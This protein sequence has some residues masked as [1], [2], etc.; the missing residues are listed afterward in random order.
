MLKKGY[1]LVE[2]LAVISTVGILASL[3]VPTF[4]ALSVVVMPLQALLSI[5]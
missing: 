4:T 2:L 1:T 3:S 5:I